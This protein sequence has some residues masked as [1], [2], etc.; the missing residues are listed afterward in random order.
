M[1]DESLLRE[2]A[3]YGTVPKFIV[4]TFVYKHTDEWEE[5]KRTLQRI[6][7]RMNSLW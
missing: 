4:P 7:M 6:R 1:I 3:R 2:L 5:R